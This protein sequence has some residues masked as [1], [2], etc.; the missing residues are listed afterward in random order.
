MRDVRGQVLKRAS[1]AMLRNTTDYFSFCI[2]M[3]KSPS[4]YLCFRII[5]LRNSTNYY[6]FCVM[7]LRNTCNY[8]C[9][10]IIAQTVGH[11]EANKLAATPRRAHLGHTHANMK[12]NSGNGPVP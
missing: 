5:M 2:M 4:N 10:C 11:T 9:F 3:L 1:R 8:Q 6:T 12:W 7:M